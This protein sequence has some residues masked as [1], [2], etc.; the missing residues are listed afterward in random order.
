MEIMPLIGC[1]EDLHLQDD[2]AIA[3]MAERRTRIWRFLTARAR[4][5]AD[6]LRLGRDHVPSFQRAC[7]EIFIE[8]LSILREVEDRFGGPYFDRLLDSFEL[9]G[10]ERHLAQPAEAAVL[11]PQ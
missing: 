9:R 4:I 11:C 6:D 3:F 1:L 5:T 2:A 7:D 8:S 10:Y